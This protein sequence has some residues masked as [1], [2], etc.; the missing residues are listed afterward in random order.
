[1]EITRKNYLLEKY[2]DV[3]ADDL[4]EFEQALEE[5]S[6]YAF[7]RVLDIDLDAK[8][9]T[10]QMLLDAAKVQPEADEEAPKNYHKDVYKTIS[11]YDKYKKEISK[12]NLENFK[13][14]VY[15]VPDG[16]YE[17]VENLELKDKKK[18][19]LLS[20]L[21]GL[22]G[23][24]SIYLGNYK[25]AIFQI[26]V[27][28]LLI[29]AIIIVSFTN[30]LALSLVVIVAVAIALAFR[31]GAEI[32]TCNYYISVINGQKIIDTLRKYRATCIS[33]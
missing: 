22:F 5:A 12:P 15:Y 31:W 23:A 21:L 25:H 4:P 1:M 11:F 8:K 20:G 7:S 28:L 2:K 32:D 26:I 19:M 9:L 30:V 10:K 6:D 16:A 33:E 17:Q 3:F 14:A 29:A 13:S 18:T 27:N 24:G